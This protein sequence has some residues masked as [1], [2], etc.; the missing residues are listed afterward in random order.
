MPHVELRKVMGKSSAED[1][2]VTVQDKTFE[3]LMTTLTPEIRVSAYFDRDWPRVDRAYA[4]LF[5]N[6]N[7]PRKYE[8]QQVIPGSKDRGKIELPGVM[9]SGEQ[10]TILVRALG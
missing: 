2:I 9:K 10:L 5:V 6:E 3:F 4:E 7:C 8:I 1:V